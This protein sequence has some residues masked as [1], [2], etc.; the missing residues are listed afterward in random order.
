VTHEELREHL[1][2]W[3]IG[4][5]RVPEAQEVERHLLTCQACS[6][7]ASGLSLVPL[8][9][10]AHR[11]VD[12]P[13]PFARTR[14][15]S[16]IQA[17]ATPGTPGSTVLEGTA[18]KQRSLSAVG[19]A[20]AKGAGVAAWLA[21]AA[22]LV[23]AAFLGWDGVRLRGRIAE[24]TTELAQARAAVAATESRMAMLQRSADRN[25]SA[26]AVLTAPDVARIDL[27]GQPDAPQASG[28]AYW[29]RARGM[30]FSAAALPPPPSGR[31]YQVWVVTSAPAPISAGL[32]EPD[33]G[34]HV[35]AVFATP[36]DIPQP[37]AVAVTLEPAGGVPA[38]TGPKVLVGTV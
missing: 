32:I 11:P 38:P 16:T 4:A 3:A 10:Q 23:L 37:I 24:L 29:S 22:A 20:K 2:A 26:L 19:S 28:R 1:E 9:L 15:L 33:S 8:A 18:D 14:L 21:M 17:A 34:G 13:S 12:T 6:E 30:V 35:S 31:T 7:I 36:P 5:L 27:A 25:Q